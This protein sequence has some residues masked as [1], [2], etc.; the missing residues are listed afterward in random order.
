MLTVRSGSTFYI[1]P[2]C[3]GGLFTPVD[4]Y[5]SVQADLWSLGVVLVNL[6]CGRNPWRQACAEDETF[7]AYLEDP[8]ILEAI[9]PLSSSASSI[10]ALLF[11]QDP[12]SRLTLEELRSMVLRTRDY[13]TLR[14]AH[15]IP[16]VSSYPSP[17]P[18]FDSSASSSPSHSPLPSPVSSPSPYPEEAPAINAKLQSWS[19]VPCPYGSDSMPVTPT[20][21]TSL[22]AIGTP[23]LIPS[24]IGR[25]CSASSGSLPPT[26]PLDAQFGPQVV[27][28]IPQMAFRTAHAKPI[29]LSQPPKKFKT[30]YQERQYHVPQVVGYSYESNFAL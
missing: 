11:A 16:V 23:G 29:K 17:T 15:P 30:R 25:T 13:T 2:E 4:S 12:N 18:S 22:K 24:G 5:S 26:P 28:H 1:S 27:Q 6:A 9:L 3:Q 20:T 8:S 10:L 7:R 14:P 21:P 19:Y